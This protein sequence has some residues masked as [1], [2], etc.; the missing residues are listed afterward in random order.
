[1]KYDL[2]ELRERCKTKL[3]ETDIWELPYCDNKH[4]KY[5]AKNISSYKSVK[6]EAKEDTSIIVSCSNWETAI[7]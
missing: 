4:R 5:N 6:I 1:M 7:K 2:K 3:I